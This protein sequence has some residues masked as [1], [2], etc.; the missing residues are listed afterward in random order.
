MDIESLVWKIIF[1]AL[2]V[3]C[4]GIA[5]IGVII[6]FVVLDTPLFLKCIVSVLC[7]FLGLT[8]F[9]VWLLCFFFFRY[10]K[11]EKYG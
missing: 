7:L 8:F 3:V 10:S 5:S 6:W 2:M 11:G 4:L 9:M 1:V